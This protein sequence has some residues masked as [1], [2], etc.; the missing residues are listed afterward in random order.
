M[1]EAER[2][3][4]SAA[5][6]WERA[7]AAMQDEDPDAPGCARLYAEAEAAEVQLREAVRAWRDTP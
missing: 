1:T 4:L 3:V 5:E 6:A 2:A 7:N